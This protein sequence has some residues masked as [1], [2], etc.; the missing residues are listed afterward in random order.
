MSEMIE[1]THKNDDIE[2]LSQTCDI[3]NRHMEKLDIHFLYFCRKACLPKIALVGINSQN[4]FSSAAFHSKRIKSS[5]PADVEHRL[6]CKI[7]RK[8]MAEMYELNLWII[9]EEMV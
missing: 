6:T 3:P 2:L 4:P 8:G 9:S 7:A 1:N 5:I